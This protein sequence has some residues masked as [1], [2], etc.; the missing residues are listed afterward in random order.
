MG[1]AARPEN[2]TAFLSALEKLLAGQGFAL[3]AGAGVSAA[4]DVY[5][6]SGAVTSPA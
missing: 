4:K 5:R 1:H 3:D 2:V 6:S